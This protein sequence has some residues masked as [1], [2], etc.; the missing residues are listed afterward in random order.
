MEDEE[1][2]LFEGNVPTETERIANDLR[3]QYKVY[4]PDTN[5]RSSIFDSAGMDFTRQTQDKI[6][7]NPRDIDQREVYTQIGNELVSNFPVYFKGLDNNEL[8]AE[9]Q[10]RASKWANGLSK[11]ALKTGASVLGGTIG[12]ITG[13]IN[14]I[15]HGTVAAMYSDD[16]N[17]MLDEYNE[18]LE[19]TMPNYYR[20]QERELGFVESMGT[21]NFW[22]ND[23]AGGLSFTLGMIVSE[24][25]WGAATGGTSLVARGALG[26]TGRWSS[27]VLGANKSLKAL[28]TWKAPTKNLINKTA[29]KSFDDLKKASVLGSNIPKALNQARFIYTSAGYEAGVEARQ[30]QK[31]MEDEWSYNFQQTNGRLPN[32][33]EIRDFRRETMDSA[34]AVYGANLALVGGS[35]MAIFGRMLL[36]KST[37]PAVSNNVLKRELFGVGYDVKDGVYTA[38]KATRPQKIAGRAYSLLKAPVIEGV[39]EEGGQSIA[40]NAVKD[41]VLAAYDE[42]ATE[43]NLDMMDSFIKGIAETYGT[44]EGRKEVGIG[45]IIGLFGGGM[46]S[47]GRFNDIGAERANLENITTY[48]NQFTPDRVLAS[49]ITSERVKASNRIIKATEKQKEAVKN[50]DLTGEFLSEQQAILA[51]I[52][53]DTALQGRK[54]GID[55]F[56]AYLNTV[57]STELADQLDMTLNEANEWKTEKL[58][59]YTALSNRYHENERY[60]RAVIGDQNFVGANT[61]NTSTEQLVKT[62]TYNLTLGEQSKAFTEKVAEDIKRAIAGEVTIEGTGTAMDVDILLSQA[63]TESQEAYHELSQ[64]VQELENQR[65]NAE[66]ELVSEQ[67]NKNRST[68]EEHAANLERIQGEIIELGEQIAKIQVNKDAAFNALGIETDLITQAELDAQAE[69]VQRLQEKVKGYERTNPALYTTLNKLFY[70][71]NKS[72]QNTVSFNNLTQQLLNPEFRLST[73]NGWLSGILKSKSSLDEATSDFLRNQIER[74]SINQVQGQESSGQAQEE[75]TTQP[76]PEVEVPDVGDEMTV[77]TEDVVVPDS[78]IDILKGKL[79]NIMGTS[80]YTTTYIGDNYDEALKNKPSEEDVNR[81]EELLGKID[82]NVLLNIDYILNAPEGYL[83]NN[84]VEIGIT[85][86]E[87][88]ELK[89]LQTKLS[90]WKVLEGLSEQGDSSIADILLHIEQLETLGEKENTKTELTDQDYIELKKSS[91]NEAA[92]ANETAEGVQSPDQ[93]MVRPIDV[94]GKAMYSFSHL[95]VETLTRLFPNSTIEVVNGKTVKDFSTL[96]SAQKAATAKRKGQKFNLVTPQG[97]VAITVGESSRLNINK[98][99]LDAVIG[100]SNIAFVNYRNSTFT[101]IYERL[102]NGDLVPLQGDFSYTSEIEGEHIELI[103][104]VVNEVKTGQIVTARLNR[105]D[106]YNKGLIDRYNRSKKTEEDYT[107]LM[108]ELHIYITD[109]EGNVVGSLR[110]SKDS[111][112]DN[113]A[114]RNLLELRRN[115]TE[116]LLDETNV[117]DYFSIGQAMPVKATL[118]GTPNLVVEETEQGARPRTIDFTDTALEQVESTGYMEGETLHLRNMDAEGVVTTFLPKETA[119]KLPVVILKVNG[120]NIAFPVSLKYTETNLS[121]A[122]TQILD[123]DLS[124]NEQINR[125]NSILIQHGFN[126]SDYAI[127]EQGEVGIDREKVKNDLANVRIFPNLADWAQDSYN[128][129]N[130]KNEAEIAIDIDNRPFHLSKVMLDLSDIRAI[131]PVEQQRRNYNSI[132]NREIAARTNIQNNIAEIVGEKMHQYPNVLES[133]WTDTLFQEGELIKTPSSDIIRRANVN[134]LREALYNENGRKVR[135][136][137]AVVVVYGEDFINNLYTQLDI[138]ENLTNLK[139]KTNTNI[140]NSQVKKEVDNQ[141]TK[142]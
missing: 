9:N 6:D 63:S 121:E 51:S 20:E 40:S 73:I 113:A 45:M 58:A 39:W 101:D 44:K 18:K 83:E 50:G 16:F 104:E 8:Y 48:R 36:G 123:T 60:I 99:N 98:E 137:K 5:Q 112:P 92:V 128:L 115:A 61:L 43:T 10:T 34:N 141:N 93:V 84:E 54:Q 23:V 64:Q 96:T 79:S 122:V 91:N 106:S 4:Q 15:R 65:T 116:Q 38:I 1:L 12:S 95:D 135:P 17:V 22:A 37:T 136:P 74:Y 70:E 130:L 75:T 127:T 142:C 32:Y 47:G 30:Y 97:S 119:E 57:D 3:Q 87:L 71:Y 108:N 59:E 85:S 52:E 132:E 129:E 2:G 102:S 49:Q 69:N 33:T 90:N 86:T 138:I 55:D 120:K 25:I 125:I 24:G 41:Y 29:A 21:A 14:G 62:L 53:R 94:A 117:S 77:P 114:T 110:A 28:N 134:L 80:K 56:A 11:M 131:G 81:Y 78:P 66:N 13:A 27:R 111:L 7:L 31:E 139:K 103:P 67:Y 35:N 140:K 109:Q 88:Q 100:E 76:E 26:A 89:D 46:S 126:P 72:K 42:E 68:P 19:F 118:I 133:R 105:N 124:R 82:S 107:N